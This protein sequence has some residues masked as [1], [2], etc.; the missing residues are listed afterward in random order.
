[1]AISEARD[2]KIKRWKRG[3]DL[4]RTPNPRVWL[5]QTMEKEIP[6]QTIEERVATRLD[7][8]I[9]L[10]DT[11]HDHKLKIQRKLDMTQNI[12]EGERPTQSF[13]HKTR[14]NHTKEEIK[15]LCTEDKERRETSDP[16]EI[17]IME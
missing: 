5:A 14:T 1:M 11:M 4:I 17:Q 12:K 2:N 8:L 16:G 7:V 15:S 9:D 3:N 13:Y 10:K 6:A